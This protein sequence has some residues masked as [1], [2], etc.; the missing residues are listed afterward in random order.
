MLN[1]HMCQMTRVALNISYQKR[2]LEGEWLRRL[3][4]I[5]ALPVVYGL[6][7]QFPIEFELHR[8]NLHCLEILLEK[9]VWKKI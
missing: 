5:T 2:A 7:G 9:S 8:R 6:V 1:W 3:L 4:Y